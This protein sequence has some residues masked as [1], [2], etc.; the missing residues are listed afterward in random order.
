MKE[1]KLTYHWAIILA[2]FLMMAASIG[3]VVNCFNLFSVEL[4]SEFGYSAISV[5][6]I[7]TIMT[8]TSFV[9]GIF[10]GK[11]YNRLGMRVALPIYVAL[12]SGGFFLYSMCS[13]LV[14]FYILSAVVGFGICGVSL[15]PCG[16]LINNWFTEK[17]GLAT[18]IAFSG[19]VVGGLI[20]VQSSKLIIAASGWR[21][22]YMVLGIASAVILLPT[23]LFIVRESPKDLGLQPFG[24]APDVKEA[25]SEEKGISLKKYMKTGS[26]RLLCASFFIIGFIGLG[27]QNNIGICL[28]KAVGHTAGFTANLFSLIMGVEIFGKII[29]GAI[30]DKKG[31]KFGSVYCAVLYCL[32]ACALILSG[33]G[34]IAIL[35]GIFFGLVSGIT[36]V[37]TP[38]LTALICGRREYSGIY[39]LISLS[40]GIGA[41]VGPVVAS[42]VFDVTG[43]FNFIWV[44]FGALSIVLIATNVLAVKKGKGFSQMLD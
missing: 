2:C 8:F 36:T 7:C 3:I 23:T 33:N 14:M 21:S 31:V 10:V 42:K 5:Q 28:T 20:V 25:L 39:G 1:R 22:A 26:A 35:F 13:S 12:M 16:M 9:G 44:V 18:G 34:K 37:T 19:S 29:L 30:Y 43:S 32:A 27:I 38:Y 40:Y 4:M 41:S 17:K 24:T 15:V 11:V 6:L